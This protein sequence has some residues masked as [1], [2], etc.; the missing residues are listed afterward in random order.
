MSS[1]VNTVDPK[2]IASA[3]NT[4][5]SDS[6][7]VNRLHHIPRPTNKEEERQWLLEQM[8]GAFR[9]FA[10]LGFSDGSSGHISLRG[11]LAL[12]DVLYTDHRGC[13]SF[14]R[15]DNPKILSNPARSGSIHTEYTSPFSMCLIWCG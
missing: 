11:T 14:G 6:G 4:E 1:F 15:S 13:C 12:L 10:K 3:L 9:I 5:T 8:A 7:E 2:R